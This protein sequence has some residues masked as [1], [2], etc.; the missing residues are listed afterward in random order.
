LASYYGYRRLALTRHAELL[1]L[2]AV[3]VARFGNVRVELTVVDTSA[4]S[5]MRVEQLRGNTATALTHAISCI[6]M[7][8]D[9]FFADRS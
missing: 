3:D 9:L 4:K 2:A 8:F 1:N 5:H 6:L 7:Q